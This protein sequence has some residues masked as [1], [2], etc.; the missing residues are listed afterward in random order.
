VPATVVLTEDARQQ[1]EHDRELLGVGGGCVGH[2]P[3]PLELDALVYE[4]RG[5]A[6]IVE[7]HV[8]TLATRP[9]QCL[10]GAPPVLV[11]RL[12]L[13]RE[14]GDATRGDGGGGMVLRRE[15]VARRPPHLGSERDER[16]DEHRSLDRH[17]Q[18]A[19]DPSAGER[20]LRAVAFAQRHQTRHLVLGEVDLLAAEV[21]QADVGDLVVGRVAS[22]GGGRCS[23][24]HV[25]T[26]HGRH[27]PAS[28]HARFRWESARITG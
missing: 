18:R 8:R 20:L 16:L 23:R 19:G 25:S 12:A 22:A 9:R 13:P 3:R 6:T 5:V 14:D 26:P 15:D 21:G 27:G 1:A 11:E 7:D 10:L 24:G 28:D 2:L 17:V 4:Q